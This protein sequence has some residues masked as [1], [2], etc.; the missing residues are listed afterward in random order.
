[1]ITELGR[2]ERGHLQNWNILEINYQNQVNSSTEIKKA[3]VKTP[4]FLLSQKLQ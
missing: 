2:S 3:G 1:M 4:A